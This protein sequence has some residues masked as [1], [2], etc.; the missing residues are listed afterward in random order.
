MSRFSPERFL[1][2]VDSESVAFYR[3]GG[4][5]RLWQLIARTAIAAAPDGEAWESALAALLNEHGQSGRAVST[6]IGDRLARYFVVVPPTNAGGMGDLRSAALLRF[7]SLF[8]DSAADW[9]IETDL[10]ATR[11]FFGSALPRTLLMSIARTIA[12]A[13]M[14]DAGIEPEFVGA[15]NRGCA[16]MRD[17]E[18]WLLHAGSE[19]GTL[20]ACAA[21]R[22]RAIARLEPDTWAS[23]QSLSAELGRAALRW[24]RPV[25]QTLYLLGAALEG[26]RESRLGALSLVRVAVPEER[27]AG[28][29]QQANPQVERRLSEA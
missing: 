9:L 10:S 16:Q 26:L 29:V 27:G 2:Q 13:G 23:P 12:G 4:R 11:P 25:P 5:S 28:A 8:G 7:E 6:R 21:G 24:D 20:A 17:G 14:R 22:L 3:I 15:W 1:L 18:A 19:C